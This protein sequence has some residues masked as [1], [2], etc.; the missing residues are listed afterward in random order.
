LYSLPAS[1][2]FLAE[3]VPKTDTLLAL[4]GAKQGRNSFRAI[5]YDGPSPPKGPIHHYRFKLYALNA[6]V[7]LPPGAQQPDLER[8]MK[9]HIIG[10]AE[11]VG[12]YS[13]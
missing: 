8:A 2:R 12:L 3:A 7:A 5:G 9:G 1:R 10:Q 4:G 6:K 13:R 11:L